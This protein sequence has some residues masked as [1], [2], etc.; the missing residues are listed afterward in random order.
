MKQLYTLLLRVA[1]LS[2]LILTSCSSTNDGKLDEEVGGSTTNGV[3]ISVTEV[4]PK[5]GNGKI[6]FSAEV[7][8][9]WSAEIVEGD[10]FVSFSLRKD[11]PTAS[12]EVMKAPM[13]NILYF[14]YDENVGIV[15]REALIRFTLGDNEPVEFT[16][17]QQS[18][19]TASNPYAGA[20]ED[21]PRWS[22]IPAKVENSNYIY[23]THTAEL[24]GKEV[25]NFSMCYDKKSYAAAWV[26]YPY[27]RAYDGSMGRTDDWGYD[28]K[29][30]REYQPNLDWSYKGS[31]DRGHQMASADRQATYELNSQTFYYS[32][33]TP[34]LD[35]LNRYE[36]AYLE[37]DIRDQVCSDTLY[38]VTG[39]D[40]KHTIGTTKDADYKQC[41]IPGAYFKVMLRT[42]SG[43][44][45][46]AISECSANE[47]K[48]IGFWVE[49]RSYSSMPTPVSVK[50]IEQ[51]TGFDFFPGVAD[52]VK[53]DFNASE[54]KF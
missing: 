12:G 30:P 6:T 36:W 1:L 49:H 25:R 9:V 22:E 51:K 13:P 5:E 44:T 37:A 47:L 31:Y 46:K 14:Y 40:Y 32:N 41:P 3:A 50:E 16:F 11:Q 8:V 53:A 29:I 39:A 23:V 17:M 28:P 42:K 34:Q 27:H 19:A 7:G 35:K 43:N 10:D 18:D 48:A 24:N 21:T 45:G 4:T 33:M 2:T 52:E 54:W 38:V 20:K 26:A 15:D